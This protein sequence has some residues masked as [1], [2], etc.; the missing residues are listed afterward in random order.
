MRRVRVFDR[1]DADDVSARAPR[2]PV[3]DDDDSVSAALATIGAAT[4][5]PGDVVARDDDVLRGHG[6]RTSTVSS[7]T[8]VSTVAGTIERVAKLVSVVPV[9]SRYHGEARDVTVTWN[10]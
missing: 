6:V 9:R 7:T 8:T 5:L 2:A 10:G 3:L 1:W 4:T